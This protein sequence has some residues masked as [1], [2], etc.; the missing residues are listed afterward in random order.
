[1]P[2]RL[3]SAMALLVVFATLVAGPASALTVG[4]L[5]GVGGLGD[6]SFNDMLYAGLGKAQKIYKF[7]LIFEEIDSRQQSHALGMQRLID[8]GADVVFANGA[9][10]IPLVDRYAVRFPEKRFVVSDGVAI[11]RPNV[12]SIVFQAHEGSFLAGALAAWMTLS[13]KVGFIGGVDT[14]P[15]KQFLQGF[16]EGV[17]YA[18]ATVALMVEFVTT[19]DDFTGFSNPG[20]GARLASAMYAGGV[21]IIFA[22]AGLTGNGVIRTAQ[23]MGKYVIGVDADQDHMAKGYVLTSM[24]KRLDRA[25]FLEVTRIVQGEFRPGT[26]DYNLSNGGVS[27]S[28]MRYTR[29]LIPDKVLEQLK[30]TESEIIAGRIRVTDVLAVDERPKSDAG[31]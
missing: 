17:G 26:T 4:F 11:S 28:P 30:A 3:H 24:M 14:L 20:K 13:G 25:A 2:R 27:L 8:R 21:D 23:K 7:R 31:Q 12:T 6:Q 18:D 16:Q 22:V 5:A 15:V 10:F 29:Q 9:N 1:M 19:G